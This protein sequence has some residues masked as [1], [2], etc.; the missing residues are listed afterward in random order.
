VILVIFAKYW[1]YPV[2]TN[3][4]LYSQNN[5]QK[6]KIIMLNVTFSKRH[7]FKFPA[8]TVLQIFKKLPI[9]GGCIGSASTFLN[10]KRFKTFFYDW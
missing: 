6:Q 2:K 5:D 8:K 4:T 1:M 10:Y 7:E 9:I 3:L